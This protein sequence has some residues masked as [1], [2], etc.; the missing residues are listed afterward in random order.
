MSKEPRL[1]DLPEV[2]D[3]YFFP[4]PG[5]PLPLSERAGPVD[6]ALPGGV[7]L[8]A[9]H[10]AP[11]PRAPTILYLHGNGECI[12]DQ[13][14]HWP[15]WATA[16][17]ANIL[18]VDYPGYASSD[19][20][21]TFTS[22]R[23]AAWAALEYLLDQPEGEVPAVIMAGRSVG[24]IFALDAAARATSPRVRGLILESGVA[25]LVKRLELRLSFA[26]LSFSAEQLYAQVRQD[27]DHQAK[28]G[29]LSFP[30]MILHTR[31]DSLVPCWNGEQLAR[32]AGARL[33]ELAL[34]ERGDH[35]DIQAINARAYQALLK[36]FVALVQ[37][38]R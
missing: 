11:R 26:P 30:V 15:A 27:F 9:Y 21:P 17:G 5:G 25:D 14:G 7:R 24:S 23:Q 32:W 33:Q 31:G 2:C 19:G 38:H 8:G 12:A 28:L 34:F 18:F 36:K 16:A 10:S 6:L 1:Y 3:T 20:E 22:C 4:M 13:L 35:N 29:G 37:P